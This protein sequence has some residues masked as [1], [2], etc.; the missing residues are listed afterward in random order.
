MVLNVQETF[1][2]TSFILLLHLALFSNAHPS[3]FEFLNNLQGSKK[4]DKIDGLHQLKQYLTKFGY[5]N[6]Q[7]NSQVQTYEVDK[8][9]NDFDDVLESAIKTYQLNY[10]LKATGTLDTQTISKMIMPRCGV[11]DI[12]NG[13]SRMRAHSKIT[14]RKNQS[15][16]LAHK[17]IHQV[18][19]YALYPGLPKWP[20]DKTNLTYKFETATP[21]N[22]TRTIGRA[23]DLWAATTP[24]TFTNIEHN[25]STVADIRIGFYS[26]DHGDGYP[27]DGP[28]GV[29]AH[30]SPPTSG[31]FH[32][33][34]DE[35]WCI[36]PLVAGCMD[37]GSVAL[38][39]IGHLLG[40]EH[41][42]VKDAIMYPSI[43]DGMAKDLHGDDIQGI[44]ALYSV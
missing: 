8:N 42:S 21:E 16:R 43:S 14:E 18:S 23:F 11:S 17:S 33:D 3:P 25:S 9:D 22:A 27:F 19:H 13:H 20:A 36:G 39:E 32:L 5:L 30:A 12:I 40:L 29:L 37:L 10:H 6:H 24:F 7:I 28:Y 34:A 1:L 4:G 35:H 2:F 31:S 41:S 38:H 26:R 15:P 44:N